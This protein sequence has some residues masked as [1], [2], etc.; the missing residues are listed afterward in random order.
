[1]IPGKKWMVV[2]FQKYEKNYTSVSVQG[3]YDLNR[4][5]SVFF[6]V[7]FNRRTSRL[8]RLP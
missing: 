6:C 7:N 2:F 5:I 8:H 4:V 1:M 3:Q